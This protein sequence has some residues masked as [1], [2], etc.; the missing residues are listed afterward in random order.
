[1]PRV[2]EIA[3]R[4]FKTPPK[5]E[6]RSRDQVRQ[7]LERSFNEGR[8]AQ[9]LVGQEAAYKRL[10]MLPDT[11][12]LRELMVELLTEQI[13]GFY[14][15]GSKTLYVV[16]SIADP[17]LGLVVSH[18]LDHSLQDQ[19]TNLD[20]LQK[21]ELSNDET[22]AVQS[23]LE[24]EA[25]YV[26]MSH[27][28]GES[29]MAGG[30]PGGWDRVR[31]EI[32]NN[33]SAMPHFASAPL[34]IQETLLFPYLSGIEFVR[35]VRQA[36]QDAFPLNALPR[37]TEQIMHSEAYAAATRDDPTTVTLPA[38][39]GATVIYENNLGEFETR[40]F[41]YQHLQD[42]QGAYR[43]ATGW[44]G[45]RYALLQ[46]PQGEALVWVSVWDSSVEAGEFHDLL[47]RVIA[48]RKKVPGRA[49]GTTTVEIQ[50][51]PAV[52]FTDAP[53]GVDARA[54]IPIGGVKLGQ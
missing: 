18:E 43:G 12:K 16:D 47:T 6:A 14:D 40:L 45:D 28:I 51:R 34:L 25:E 9:Q 50:G 23:V 33:Q 21:A 46:T 38:P 39:R 54:L 49:M 4:K 32:R 31:Q 17:M 26:R 2:E 37:S 53:A 1:M 13:V 27:L 3:R 20:S 5:V 15:P 44:D 52:I 41:L 11:L 10:G 30:L 35:R 42:Q 29:N 19:Y 36:N 8:A 24:G 48:E 22:G 7:F